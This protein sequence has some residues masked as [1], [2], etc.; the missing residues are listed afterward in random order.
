VIHTP[1]DGSHKPFTIGLSQLDH[2]AWIEIDEN[3]AHYLGEKRRLYREETDNVLVAEP[4]TEAAQQEVLDMLVEHLPRHFPEIY[5]RT[6]DLIAMR[7]P[8]P[9]HPGEAAIGGDDRLERS[10]IATAALLVQEDLVLMRKSLEG[11]RLVAASLCFPSAWNLHEKFGK[12]LHEIHQP[13]PG[14]GQGTRNA[15]LID[16][17]FDNLRPDHSVKRWNWSL[18]GDARLY[19]PASDNGM[20]KRF[21]DG[22]LAGN[23][24]LRLERQTLRKLPVSGDILFTIRI[25]IEPL[26]VLARHPD[27]RQLASAISEQINAMSEAELSYK[28]FADERQRL[29]ARLAQLPES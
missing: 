24:T 21:G 22:D 7:T 14:F 15:G 11:W 4:G 25:Y 20:K 18:Y 17:M 5:Q 19:H 3:L 29:T 9:R 23:V 27:G 28:G 16:R 10:A 12:P 2:A 13:V 6:D 1:Y 8:A 26:E